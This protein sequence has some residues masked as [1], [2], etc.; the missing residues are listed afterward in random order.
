MYMSNSFLAV[1]DF[2]HLLIAFANRNFGPDQTLLDLDRNCLTLC[3]IMFLEDIK[4]QNKKTLKESAG[5][6]KS[7]KN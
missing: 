5:A 6:D 3:M 4:K 1:G 7:M 2:C